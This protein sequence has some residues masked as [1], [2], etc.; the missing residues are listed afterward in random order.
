MTFKWSWEL[1]NENDNLILH[2]YIPHQEKEFLGIINFSKRISREKQTLKGR[3]D[4][5]VRN[6]CNDI[7]K[8]K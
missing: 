5:D 3:N 2:D 8:R 7:S 6:L 4:L 1:E